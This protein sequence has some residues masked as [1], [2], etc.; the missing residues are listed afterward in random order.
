MNLLMQ[1]TAAVSSSLFRQTLQNRRLWCVGS[2]QQCATGFLIKHGATPEHGVTTFVT[3]FSWTMK[4][5]TVEGETNETSLKITEHFQSIQVLSKLK[6]LLWWWRQQ[7][8]HAFLIVTCAVGKLLFIHIRK[9]IFLGSY[10]T[11]ASTDI[12]LSRAG[13]ECFL[14]LTLWGLPH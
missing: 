1:W 6:H 8:Q 2:D 7:K 12:E 10:Y 11:T 3:H 13:K 5:Q 9:T 14:S 4:L